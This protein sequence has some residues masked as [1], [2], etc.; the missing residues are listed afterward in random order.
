VTGVSRD[1]TCSSEREKNEPFFCQKA[2]LSLTGVPYSVL[3]WHITVLR[4]N[5]CLLVSIFIVPLSDGFKTHQLEN[6]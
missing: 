1:A 2:S 4:I 6:K 5:T 3:F